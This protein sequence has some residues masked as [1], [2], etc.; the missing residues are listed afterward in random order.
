MYYPDLTPYRYSFGDG[1]PIDPNVLN[2]GWL[3]AQRPF[4]KKRA[5]EE[6][7]DAL[8]E[9]CLEVVYQ[10][11]GHHRCPFCRASSSGVEVSR[12]GKRSWLGSAEIHIEGKD[13]KIYAA[14]DLIYHYVAAHDYAPPD[15]FV[16]AVFQ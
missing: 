3:D 1:D 15:E 2:V 4:P 14:P 7:L 12:K 9:R 10:T 11:R 8:F 13:G 16:E 6:F 5:S